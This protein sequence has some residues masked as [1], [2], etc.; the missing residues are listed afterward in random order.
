MIKIGI[1]SV[2]LVGRSMDELGGFVRIPSPRDSK[3]KSW[4]RHPC[5]FFLVSVSVLM[6]LVEE[7]GTPH[8][9]VTFIVIGCGNR[10][11]GYSRYAPEN[12]ER[13]RL[14]A[15]VD[16]IPERRE[17]V[18]RAS[19]FGKKVEEYKDWHDL[20]MDPIADVAIIATQDNAHVEPAVALLGK[21]YHILLEKPMATNR[22]DCLAIVEAWKKARLKDPTRILA[23]CHIMRYTAYSREINRIIHSGA[24]GDLMNIQH[25]E[26]VGHFHFA[27]SYVRGKW[28]NQGKCGSCVLLA[29]SC[30]D[31]DWLIYQVGGSPVVKLSSFGSLTHFTKKN[32]PVNATS[33][34]L[35]C[36][37]ADSGCPYSA[38]IIY[39]DRVKSGH[40]RWPVNVLT[41]GIPDI[42]SVEQALRTGPYGRCVYDCD[43]DQ[44][45]KQMVMLEFKN[46]VTASFTM[47]AFTK[48]ICVRKTRVFGTLGEL[49][50]DGKNI[51]V[52]TFLP[53]F[54]T[55]ITPRG[56]TKEDTLLDGHDGADWYLMNAFMAA[57]GTHNPDL[58]MTGP[59]ESLESHLCVFAA[60]D[61]RITNSVV[62]PIY[63]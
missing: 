26:P 56:L 44:P 57:V 41:P 51:K 48:E 40:T 61:A 31:I 62:N 3:K 25:L 21:G 9:M 13:A 63:Y 6:G 42:E 14:I 12:P 18:V 20:P 11:L 53:D 2:R 17:L 38:K 47:V 33:R 54:T 23:V 28:S 32:K 16:P 8:P 52:T 39:L 35:D 19:G 45:D 58:I 15:V 55:T 7:I 59:E 29:K 4:E 37:L 27:H 60:E 1:C 24:I 22:S 30:H 49:E 34:C 36:P 46:G 5:V 43:N 50:C 10:G